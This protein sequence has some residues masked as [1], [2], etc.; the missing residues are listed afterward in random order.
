MINRKAFPGLIPR[1]DYLKRISP[2]IGK[3]LIKVLTGQRRVGKSFILYQ[4]MDEIAKRDPA[5]EIIYINK[6]LHEFRDIRDGDELYRHV[7]AKLKAGAPN[8]LFIDE[9]QDVKGFELAL[10][11][12]LAEG[13]CDIYC[14]GSNAD[15]LSGELATYLAGRHVEFQIHPLSYAEFLRFHRLENSQESLA[16]YLRFG[17][18]PYLSAIGLDEAVAFEYLDTVH[19]SILLRDVVARERIRNVDFLET[20]LEYVADNVGS[21]FSANNISKYLKSQH[22]AMPVPTILSYLSALQRAFIIRK[23]R[24][25]DLRGLKLFEVGEKYYFEDLG[26]RNASRGRSSPLDQGKLVENAVYLRLVERGYEVNVG[27]LDGL[28]IDFVAEKAGRKLYVQAAYLVSDES[29][30]A[31]EFGNLE[32]I[33]DNYPKYVVSMDETLGASNYKGIEQVGLREFLMMD[34]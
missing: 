22:V 15:L 21:L 1:P 3:G 13:R 33:D 31:R 16:R 10:R 25:A 18:M 27:W 6:E 24:R 7:A 12:L 19:A 2:F 17:G 4:L 32:R 9:I 5:V 11:S 20:L 34:I 23:A 28:E 30:A 29:T 26:L 14:T 8:A